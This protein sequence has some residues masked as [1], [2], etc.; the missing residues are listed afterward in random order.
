[1][2][3]IKGVEENLILVVDPASGELVV[4]PDA[5]SSLMGIQKAF[6]IDGIN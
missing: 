4:V 6:V 3:I 5:D 2:G 1:V